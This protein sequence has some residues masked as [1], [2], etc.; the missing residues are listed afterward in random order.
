[1][2]KF[3]VILLSLMSFN[4]IA[5]IAERPSYTY[6]SIALDR[7]E[8]IV[9]SDNSLISVYLTDDAKKFISKNEL[10]RYTK[11]KM[12]NFVSAIKLINESDKYDYNYLDIKLEL[13]KY[14][15]QTRIYY[16][17]ISLQMYPSVSWSKGSPIPYQLTSAI[18]GSEAQLLTFIKQDIDLMIETFAEDY[19][20]ISDLT[21]KK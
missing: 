12:R 3:I 19:Y 4:S 2:N 8:W 13:N 20:H 6:P 18:A 17:L 16:G 1:M 9:N 5:G 11:L 21:E 15:D 14:N 7:Y 10:E